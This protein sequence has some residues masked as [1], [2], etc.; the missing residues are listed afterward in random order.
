[1]N[2]YIWIAA[3]S[4]VSLASGCG[5]FKEK[6]DCPKFN[7]QPPTEQHLPDDPCA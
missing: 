1:M 5:L 2:Q 4:I 7:Y 3:L 6:C